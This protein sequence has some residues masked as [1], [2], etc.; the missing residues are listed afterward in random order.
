MALQLGVWNQVNDVRTD[1]G[2]GLVLDNIG[3]YLAKSIS[4][5]DEPFNVFVRLR[6][7]F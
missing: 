3:V 7:R 2:I 4:N 5:S 6:P 1:I